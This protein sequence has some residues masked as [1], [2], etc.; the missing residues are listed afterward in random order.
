MGSRER[1]RWDISQRC[2]STVNRRVFVKATQY[3]WSQDTAPDNC[4]VQKNTCQRFS[5]LLRSSGR[6][7]PL[8]TPTPFHRSPVTASHTHTVPQVT[9]HR[10]SHGHG[11]TGDPAPAISPTYFDWSPVPPPHTNLDVI[12]NIHSLSLKHISLCL[13]SPLLT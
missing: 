7:T 9:R 11:S 8:L 13:P 10:S 4:D 2:D 6:P 1:R 5:R 3:I 12:V